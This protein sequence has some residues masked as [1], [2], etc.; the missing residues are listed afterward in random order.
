M[1]F[2]SPGLSERGRPEEAVQEGH[3]AQDVLPGIEKTHL[4]LLLFNF[5][6][7]SQSFYKM[8]HGNDLP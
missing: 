8:Q 5:L 7:H 4:F 6:F 3:A 2:C 1:T